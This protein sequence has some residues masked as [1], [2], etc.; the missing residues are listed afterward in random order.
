[1][2]TQQHAELVCPLKNNSNPVPVFFFQESAGIPP[3]SLQHVN[4]RTITRKRAP[5]KRVVHINS[6]HI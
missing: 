5:L 4:D 1:M 3:A 2:K 6:T